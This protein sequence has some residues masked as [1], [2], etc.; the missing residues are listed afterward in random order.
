[1]EII[2]AR[3]G[4]TFSPGD[5][6]VR[7]GLTEDLDLVSAGVEQAKKAGQFIFK[8]SKNVS[9]VYSGTLKRTRQFAE[10][11]IEQVDPSLKG[12]VDPRL[13]EIDY[14]LW[15]GLSDDEIS[16]KYGSASL[17]AWNDRSV[18]PVGAGFKPSK[19]VIV[20]EIRDLMMEIVENHEP[21]STVVLVS[22]N[23][24][25]RYFLKIMDSAFEKHVER[26]EF[27]VSTGALCKIGYRE[28]VFSLS[29]W[30][31]RP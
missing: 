13:D 31:V 24:K 7:A 30:N 21:D 23:G 9:A 19:E 20:S 26:R 22:S 27:K 29:Y 12:M 17:A 1:M 14:G 3:H 10:I 5:K 15:A 18:W 2:L 4:N 8:D 28:G 6:V 25:L 16:E 11:L